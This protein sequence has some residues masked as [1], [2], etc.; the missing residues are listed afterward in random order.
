MLNTLRECKED[1]VRG[2]GEFSWTRSSV[3]RYL[4]MTPANHL[5][6]EKSI[7]VRFIIIRVKCFLAN[8]M[9]FETKYNIKFTPNEKMQLINILPVQAV[10]IHIVQNQ[11][12]L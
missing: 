12:F 7:L 2:S 1:M 5:T 8:L 9:D 6:Q 10:D 4:E 3:M 11:L